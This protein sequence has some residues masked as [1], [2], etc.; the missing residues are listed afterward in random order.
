MV[1]RTGTG[2]IFTGLNKGTE[3]QFTIRAR[4]AEGLG[5]AKG[6]VIRTGKTEPGKIQNL[7]TSIGTTKIE[8]KWEESK[9][10]GGTLIIG[11][12]IKINGSMVNRT[13]TGIIFTGLNKGTEYQFTI[14]ARNAEGLGEAR[15]Q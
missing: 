11:Y 12:E 2:I 7:T 9:D 13:G 3:Y 14:R 10:N 15:E 5:E 4:N 1:N 8:L 6:T